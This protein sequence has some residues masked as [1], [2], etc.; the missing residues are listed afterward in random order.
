MLNANVAPDCR[1][2]LDSDSIHQCLSLW[3][4][5]EMKEDP[6]SRR[7]VWAAE[8]RTRNLARTRRPVLEPLEQRML[9]ATF[10][11]TNTGDVDGLG[12]PV[13]GSFREAII[14]AN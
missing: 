14:Q 9:L 12:N 2:S 11:V 10:R 13:P 3:D 5:R 7:R 1:D 4:R 6:M 8:L